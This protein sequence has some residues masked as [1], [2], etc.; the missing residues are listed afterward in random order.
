MSGWVAGAVV[1]GAVINADAAGSAADTQAGAAAQSGAVSLQI[2]EKQ[3]VAQKDT[4]TQQLAADKEALDKQLAAQQS[5]LTQTLAAQK[6]A[7]DTGNTVAQN[8]LTQQLAAQKVAL[9]DTLK[10]QREMFNKQVENLSSYK[11]AGETG[12]TRLLDLLGLSKNKD[13]PG[14]GSATT[15]FKVEGFDP[16]T[17]FNEFNAKEMEQDPGY[18]FRLAEGQKAI[19]R[20]TAA[21]GGLQSGAALKAAAEYGQAMGSQE[22][23][24]A[25]NRFMANKAFKSQEFSNAFNRFTTERANQLAPLQSLQGVGQAAAAG[26]ANAAGNLASGGSQAIQNAG[27]GTSAAYGGY[28]SATGNIASNLGAGTSAAYGNYG[29]GMSNAYAGS[30]AARQSAYGTAGSNLSN[31][32]ANQ[33][34]GQINALTGAANARAAGQIGTANAFTNAIGQGI[35]AY[36]M[37]QQNQLF[38]DYLTKRSTPSI[39]L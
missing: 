14:Y 38:N 17:L 15:A 34:A 32:Y 13:A 11:A 31:I 25:Y 37:Y 10:L 8:M 21:R 19:E 3:I 9:D 28:G 7:A 12:Q 4:L 39:P 27:A 33:G 18:A 6:Q 23:G 22:Y 1:V 24:N 20:S 30:G 16:K 5:T 26:Q 35:N 2:A 29:S 36:G